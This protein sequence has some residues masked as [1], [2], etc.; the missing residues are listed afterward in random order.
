MAVLVD[1]LVTKGTTEPYRMFTSRAEHRLLLREGN[2]DRRLTALG[3][4]LGLVRDGQW[5]LFS[6]KDREIRELSEGLRAIVI[7]PDGATR[8]LL[9]S[10]GASAP[11]KAVTLEEILRQPEVS[12]DSLAAFWDRIGRADPEALRE[13]ETEAKYAGYLRRQEDLVARSA[14]LEDISLPE[15]LEYG[16]VAGLSREIVEKLT[17]IRPASLG[18]A[19]RVSGVTPAALGCLEIHLKKT[20]SL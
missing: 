12:V 14:H 7:R 17:G 8:D 11:G 1:D 6:A 15:G 20:G 18:Q 2:A 13:V 9:A 19:G 16:E 4:D 10:I 5:E 3:R